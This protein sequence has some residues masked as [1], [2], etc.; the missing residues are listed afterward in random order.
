MRLVCPSVSWSLLKF[1]SMESVMP[2]NH[3]VLCSLISSLWKR[4]LLS[5]VHSLCPHGPWDSLGQNTGVGSCSLLQGIFPT[6][7]SN[8]GLPHCRRILYQLSL[9]SSPR[10]L[11]WVAYSFSSRSSR[12]RNQTRVSC[13]ADSLPAELPG[14]PKSG[15]K[16][17]K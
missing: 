5:C 2:S 9:Q 17:Q 1:M 11:E 15:V 13:I 16:W 6:Q 12:P 7:G 4:K 8:P 3:L 14:K 10:I